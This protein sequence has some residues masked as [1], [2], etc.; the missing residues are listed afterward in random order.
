VGCFNNVGTAAG[1]RA[2]SVGFD[3]VGGPLS[4]A[5]ELAQYNAIQAWATSVGAN[6]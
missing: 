3:V 5:Q 2:S 4:D 6:V 1:F